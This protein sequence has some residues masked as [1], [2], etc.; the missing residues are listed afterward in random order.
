MSLILSVS[1]S[2]IGGEMPVDAMRWSRV[3]IA[4]GIQGGIMRPRLL[5]LCALFVFLAM[6]LSSQ[7]R[8]Y[9]PLSFKLECSGNDC[10]LLS[11]SPQT[12]GM[13][14]GFVRLKPGESVDAHSTGENEEALVVLRG[15]GMVDVKGRAP[16]PVS[17][18]MLVYIPPRSRHNVTNT[19]TEVL[20]YVYVVAPVGK[21]P[22]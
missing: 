11:G 20:E 7:E 12:T 19:G 3:E 21:S 17:S 8:S 18:R 22:Q 16:V 4:S 2:A 9:Q 13:R 15:E 5:T 1:R 14:C 10:P 6:P